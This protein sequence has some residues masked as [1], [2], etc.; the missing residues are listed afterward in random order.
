MLR[1]R[2][3]QKERSPPTLKIKMAGVKAT[4]SLLV[5]LLSAVLV[6]EAASSPFFYQ[7]YSGYYGQRPT[8]GRSYDGEG[9][10]RYKAICRVHA[11]DSLA[12]PGRIGN[13]VCPY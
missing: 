13:P 7:L 10:S 5:V 1:R 4:V 6:C 11:V 8:H 3:L 9:E 12:F 2:W